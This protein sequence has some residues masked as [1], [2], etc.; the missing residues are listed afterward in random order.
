MSDYTVTMGRRFRKIS[1]FAR[2]KGKKYGGMMVRDVMN[3]V[4]HGR[5]GGMYVKAINKRKL[6]RLGRSARRRL[7]GYI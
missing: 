4:R 3:P 5:V 7:K 2:R 6:R 1:R